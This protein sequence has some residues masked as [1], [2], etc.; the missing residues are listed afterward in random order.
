MNDHKQI[1][2]RLVDI[3]FF[4]RDN[5]F[6][7]DIEMF[8]SCYSCT[9]AT[10]QITLTLD[11]VKVLHRLLSRHIMDAEPRFPELK[12]ARVIEL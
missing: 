10:Q 5:E 11:E 8:T 2:R 3:D 4:S 12:D 1:R 9:T 6:N 7:I